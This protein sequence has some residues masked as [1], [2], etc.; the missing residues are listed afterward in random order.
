MNHSI[1]EEADH[2]DE[3]EEVEV[4]GR[5]ARQAPA[6]HRRPRNT[7][8]TVLGAQPRGLK[9]NGVEHLGEGEREHDEI[10]AAHADREE[11]DDERR[12]RG[13]QRGKR[14]R[15]HEPGRLHE[16]QRRDVAADT[17]EGRVPEGDHSRVA[18]QQVEAHGEDAPDKD[19][20]EQLD[21]VVAG[22]ERRSGDDP[23][24]D[25]K[26]NDANYFHLSPAEAP[27]QGLRRP[28][29]GRTSRVIISAP[30]RRGLAVGRA[31]PAP[32]RRK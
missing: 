14:K 3:G 5:W 32:S 1:E 21:W 25:R 6:E 7:D 10:H 22:E 2:D 30:V 19:L 11:T 20:L 17:E 24:E 31:G 26:S 23:H 8:E 27:A 16:R 12:R 29:F 18:H 15:G 9:G 28:A 13:R 4:E